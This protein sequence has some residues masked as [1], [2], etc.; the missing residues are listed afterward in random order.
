MAN[1]RNFIYTVPLN[2]IT[3][4]T[5]TNPSNDNNRSISNTRSTYEINERRRQV[6]DV[7]DDYIDADQSSY[8]EIA[9]TV[10]NKDDPEMLCL[11]F[12]SWF[13]GLMFA[14]GLAFVNQYLY[15]STN[16]IYITDALIPLVSYPFGILLA[17]ILPKRAIKIGLSG[18]WCFSLNPG[19]FSI[20]EH[21]VIYS[22]AASSYSSYAMTIV[23]IKRVLGTETVNFGI[24]LILLISTQLMGFGIADNKES[25][26]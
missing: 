4:Q 25:F 9:G 18:N 6:L 26:C 21:V 11:T 23:D 19:P 1:V 2:E 17:Y 15:Y 13:I 22:M 14:C 8:E 5:N 12:R 10:S 3:L 20:K 24:G 7:K 16:S